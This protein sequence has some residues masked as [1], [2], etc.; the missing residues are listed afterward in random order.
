MIKALNGKRNELTVDSAE[1]VK[2]IKLQLQEIEGIR[3]DQLRLIF[4]GKLLKD[5]EKLNDKDIIDGSL[6]HS[7]I[8][9]RGWAKYIN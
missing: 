9:L 6:V 3:Y 4:K 7:A 1:T 8:M 5:D 2:N